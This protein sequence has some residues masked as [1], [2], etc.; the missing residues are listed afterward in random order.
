VASSTSAEHDLQASFREGMSRLSTGIVLVTTYV[1][2]VP[3]GLTVSAC[4]SVSLDPPQL[5]V[6]LAER[7]ATA[8]AIREQLRFGVNVL[9]ADAVEIAKLGAAPGQRKD[10][11]E[12]CRP[13]RGGDGTAGARPPALRCALAH[14]ECEPDQLIRAGD[15]LI[16]IARVLDVIDGPPDEQAQEDTTP[17]VHFRREFYSVARLEPERA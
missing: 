17:L 13:D 10:I 6:S 4:C 5:L 12:Y 11:T 1:E 7:T 2:G 16:V 14:F 3:W 15:H 8:M 9:G